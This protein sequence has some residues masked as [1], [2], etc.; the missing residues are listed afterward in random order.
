MITVTYSFD[1]NATEISADLPFD[2]D[3]SLPD[4][5]GRREMLSVMGGK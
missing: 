3:Y 1:S 5:P 2:M 4:P